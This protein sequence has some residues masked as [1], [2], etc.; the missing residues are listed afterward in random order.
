MARAVLNPITWDKCVYAA[1]CHYARR[2]F[3]QKFFSKLF[4]QVLHSLLL[5]E[6][7]YFGKYFVFEAQQHTQNHTAVR[8]HPLDQFSVIANNVLEGYVFSC[9]DG[10]R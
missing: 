1:S 10:S 2:F 3:V 6:K 4:I 8:Q 5:L 9:R 7:F